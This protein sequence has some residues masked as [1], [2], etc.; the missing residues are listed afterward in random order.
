MNSAAE[1]IAKFSSHTKNQKCHTY[2]AL[3]HLH[4]AL[5]VLTFISYLSQLI[6]ESHLIRSLPATLGKLVFVALASTLLP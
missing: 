2:R 6:W 1:H 3:G 5:P 4:I